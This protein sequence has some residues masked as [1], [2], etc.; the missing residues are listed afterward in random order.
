MRLLLVPECY[1]EWIAILFYTL[2]RVLDGIGYSD[3][4][5]TSDPPVFNLTYLLWDYSAYQ[6]D[7]VS[8]KAVSSTLTVYFLVVKPPVEDMCILVKEEA[9]V[10]TR[11]F[12][13]G[14]RQAS[15]GQS[16]P[17]GPCGRATV[18]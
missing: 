14:E 2:Y 9:L 6:M 10:G 3:L 15:R 16:R 1:R 11:P 18:N 12:H 8:T 5:A 7:W 17:S 13:C 4:Y